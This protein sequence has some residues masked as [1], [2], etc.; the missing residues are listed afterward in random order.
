MAPTDPKRRA[1]MH[2]IFTRSADL[3]MD[4][5]GRITLPA[6]LLEAAGFVIEDTFRCYD[7]RPVDESKSDEERASEE[8]FRKEVGSLA[9][10]AAKT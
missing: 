6:H 10:R 3:K 7:P 8:H 1:F 9:L 2:A 5:T 4:D